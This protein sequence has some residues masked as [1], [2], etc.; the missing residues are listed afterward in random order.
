ML[1][2]KNNTEQ[3]VS[4]NFIPLIDEYSKQTLVLEK[5][6]KGS[7]YIE[8]LFSE[9]TKKLL[10]SKHSEEVLFKLRITDNSIME[11]ID[12]VVE[13]DDGG[14][15]KY[16]LLFKSPDQFK[17]GSKIT[18]EIIDVIYEESLKKYY[19]KF[20]ITVRRYSKYFR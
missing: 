11:E 3:R 7:Y 8:F 10:R 15:G 2:S 12:I 5:I 19:D 14:L 9:T 16:L 1:Y 18:I 4:T 17:R 13:L 6:V 20:R